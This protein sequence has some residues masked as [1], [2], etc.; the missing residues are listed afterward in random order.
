MNAI[1]Y[2]AFGIHILSIIAILVLLLLQAKKN[3]KKLNRG[4]LHATLA[5]LVAGEVMYGMFMKIHPDKVLNHAK[6][7]VKGL[8][9][10]VI[11]TLGYSNAKKPILKN[12]IWAAMLGLTILNV[13]I[14]SF[15]N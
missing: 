13:L 5:A 10:A 8:V 14:A 7:G 12:S 3:P 6:Y 11:L 15:W 9:I 1:Y 4:I 2:I